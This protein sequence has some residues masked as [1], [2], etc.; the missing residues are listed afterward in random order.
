MNADKFCDRWFGFDAMSKEERMAA[1]GQWGHR[2]Q[3]VRVLS[4]ILDKP[5]NTVSAWGADF[6]RMPKDLEFALA[7]VDAMC[8]QWLAIA[9]ARPEILKLFWESFGQDNT[10]N[11]K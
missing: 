8:L 9:K 1:K 2:Q 10:L 6:E 5:E 7:A 11:F 3:R 4:I